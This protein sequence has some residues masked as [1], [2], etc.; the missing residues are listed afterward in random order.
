MWAQHVLAGDLEAAAASAE[1]A[2]GGGTAIQRCHA[3]CLLAATLAALGRWED[4]WEALRHLDVVLAPI[5]EPAP[6]IRASAAVTRT[7]AA[8][9]AGQMAAAADAAHEA[10]RIAGDAGL[11]LLQID[12]LEA[13]AAV[14]LAADEHTRAARLLAAADAH[15]HRRGY[16][17]RF[18]SAVPAS[19]RAQLAADHADAWAEGAALTVA[20][21]TALAQRSRGPRGRP[22]FGVGA[23]T[24]TE[25]LVVDHVRH[26][27]T[28]AE[29]AAELF[30]TVP[31]V[32]THLT[33]ILDKLGVRNRAELASRRPD[34]P[35]MTNGRAQSGSCPHCGGSWRMSLG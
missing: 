33:R 6:R 8:L 35:Y 12:A 30:V 18:T 19:A 1:A 2:A 17:G 13:V 32:K 11:R 22:S 15:R 23:L 27:R 9:A 14:A 3:R 25:R 26:G 34:R 16:R 7:R 21:A 10:L 31:T 5:T 20:E 28:N 29:I 4:T 24:P